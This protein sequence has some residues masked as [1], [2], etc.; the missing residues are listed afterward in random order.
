M[1]DSKARHFRSQFPT[2]IFS[3]HPCAALLED[4]DNVVEASM[5][6]AQQ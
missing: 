1:A 4:P 6:Y 2:G 3:G 5:E